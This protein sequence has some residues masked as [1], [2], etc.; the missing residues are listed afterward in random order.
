VHLILIYLHLGRRFRLF[1]H[2]P[3]LMHFLLCQQTVLI[4]TSQAQRLRHPF[5]IPRNRYQAR[6]A[7]I[8]CIDKAMRSQDGIP[9]APAEANSTDLVGARDHFDGVDEAVD[10]GF[11]DGFAVYE[12]PG[13]KGSTDFGRFDALFDHGKLLAD[14][15]GWF[16]VVEEGGV[17]GVA[18]QDVGEVDIEAG[19]GVVIGQETGIGKVEAEDWWMVKFVMVQLTVRALLSLMKMTVLALEPSLGSAT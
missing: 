4:P 6:M 8:R 15:E 19:L 14:F 12:K 18:I 7:C 13:A 16:D 2:V 5:K 11:G 3:N 1:Q 9:T 17:D 10:N